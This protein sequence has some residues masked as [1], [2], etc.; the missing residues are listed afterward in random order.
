MK[1][2]E[3]IPDINLSDQEQRKALWKQILDNPDIERRGSG[4]TLEIK[5]KMADQVVGE[6]SR[7]VCKVISKS[8]ALDSQAGTQEAMAKLS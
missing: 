7:Q 1:Y 2:H 8:Q 4:D 5:V 3:G 6:R